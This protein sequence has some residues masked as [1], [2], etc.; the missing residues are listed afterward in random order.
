[1]TSTTPTP[2]D[3]SGFEA[4][5]DRL[6]GHEGGYVNDRRDPGGETKYGISK[7][8]YPTVDIAGLSLEHAKTIYKRDYWDRMGCDDLQAALRF[9]L[10]DA[11]VNSGPGNAARWLQKTVGVAQDG[12]IGPITLRATAQCEAASLVARYCG[13]RLEFM[14]SLSTWQTF[15][16]GW[17]RRIAS[18]LME[19]S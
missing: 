14:A 1:M 7:R 12:V 17:A 5:F 10:F 6:I 2:T 18:N 9:H 15:G 16:R 8:S 13:V 4:C 3:L 19:A 11:A